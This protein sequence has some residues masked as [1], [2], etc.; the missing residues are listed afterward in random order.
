MR[1]VVDSNRRWLWALTVL[2]LLA[3]GSGSGAPDGGPPSV[4]SS[5]PC[6][7][8]AS[9]VVLERPTSG[10]LL[11]SV[12]SVPWEGGFL[13]TW[14]EFGSGGGSPV[15]VFARSSGTEFERIDGPGFSGVEARLLTGDTS[16]VFVGTNGERTLVYSSLSEG[17]WTTASRLAVGTDEQLGPRAICGT[18]VLA[19][20]V[21]LSD[22]ETGML[23]GI[24]GPEMSVEAVRYDLGISSWRMD[25]PDSLPEILDCIADEEMAIALTRVVGGL[26]IVQW[27]LSTDAASVHALDGSLSA[28]ADGLVLDID[29]VALAFEGVVQVWTLND[30][31]WELESAAP[32]GGMQ[33]RFMGI[34]DDPQPSMFTTSILGVQMYLTGTSDFVRVTD[35]RCSSDSVQ[36]REAAVFDRRIF[37]L[38]CI[39]GNAGAA[40]VELSFCDAT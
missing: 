9:A 10:G 13:L 5:H 17:T 24:P 35:M 21:Y 4:G 29:R 2:G 11:D 28:V 19:Q 38:S 26:A 40:L 16:P 27:D 8:E 7:N 33:S 37:H 32:G 14:R 3:C 6:W 18:Q 36:G 20:L 34:V 23:F 31:V 15:R 30:G 1:V 25:T 39:V 22:G 12:Q